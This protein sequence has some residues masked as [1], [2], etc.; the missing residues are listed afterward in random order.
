[1]ILIA[2]A[3][4]CVLSVPLRGGHL[5]RLADL[6]LRGLWIPVLAL[7][8]QVVITETDA[9]GSPAA[10]RAAHIASYALI[11][12]FLWLNRQLPGV[13]LIGLGTLSNAVAIIANG[14]VMPASRTAERLS[15]LKLGPGFDNSAPL[16]HPALAWL[17][18]VIPWP[19]PLPNVLSVGDLL[20]FSGTLV[21]LHRSCTQRTPRAGAGRS[22]LPAR[23]RRGHGQALGQ[24]GDL[25]HALHLRGKRDQQDELDAAV[26]G[27]A[28]ALH[29]HPE[30]RRIHERDLGQL[31]LDVVAAVQLGGEVGFEHR[32]GRE[33]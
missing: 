27:A 5:G 19:G 24:S 14:G 12:V 32:R 30:T 4:L 11:A 23:R 9:G 20:I 13:R 18:D 21:L 25:E 33:V 1:M 2:L 8:L 16:A 6:R 3:A 28:R 15:G 17:G 31:Q 22:R 29:E 7:G 26:G 10:H